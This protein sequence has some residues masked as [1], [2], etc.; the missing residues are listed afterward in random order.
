MSGSVLGTVCKAYT[1][2]S[3]FLLRHLSKDGR[4]GVRVCLLHWGLDPKP[5]GLQGPD[6]WDV[7]KPNSS[8]GLCF[9]LPQGILMRTSSVMM[10]YGKQR[11]GGAL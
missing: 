9:L 4:G 1:R 10:N 2:Q 11:H 6:W 5:Q 3:P 7:H 8:F